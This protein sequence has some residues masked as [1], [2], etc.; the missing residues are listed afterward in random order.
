ME[1]DGQGTLILTFLRKLRATEPRRGLDAK[2]FL[3]T[4][5]K[6]VYFFSVTFSPVMGF[7][8]KNATCYKQKCSLVTKNAYY[9]AKL[10][11]LQK[12]CKIYLKTKK[13]KTFAHC[14]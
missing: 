2:L 14:I 9:D 12:S 13:Y 6:E 5:T 10:N 11:P 1:G 4:N 7:K 3:N 8:L